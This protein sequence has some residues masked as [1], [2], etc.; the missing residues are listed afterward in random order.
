M[1][2]SNANAVETLALS[3]S[4]LSDQELISA[5]SP[6]KIP[7][8]ERMSSPSRGK[9]IQTIAVTQP[10]AKIDLSIAALVD[11]GF[12]AGGTMPETLLYLAPLA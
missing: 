5:V 8:S 11:G 4:A 2:E 3:A 9:V 10:I 12:S 6:D 7:K 1:T